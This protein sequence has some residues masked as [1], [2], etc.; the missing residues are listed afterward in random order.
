MVIAAQS[1]QQAMPA[2]RQ[3]SLAC[4]LLVLTAIPAHP[5]CPHLHRK[6]SNDNAVARVLAPRLKQLPRHAALWVWRGAGMM[7]DGQHDARGGQM[8]D[9]WT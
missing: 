2:G 3:V 8:V 7:V 1:V 9:G 4:K 5:R 6:V